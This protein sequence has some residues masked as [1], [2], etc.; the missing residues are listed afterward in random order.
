[1]S[2]WNQVSGIMAIDRGAIDE[3][4]ISMGLAFLL[5]QLLAWVYSCTHSGVSYSKSFVQSLV[6][7][8]VIVTL[9]MAIIGNNMVI[10]FGMLGALSM[11]RFRNV[12]KDTRDTAFVFFAIVNGIACGT[13]NYM[14]AVAGSVFFSV[15]L[16]YLHLIAFGS[17]RNSDAFIRFSAN[18]EL[19]KSNRIQRILQQHCFS[20]DMVTQRIGETGLMELAFQLILR[21]PKHG[22]ELVDELRHKTDLSSITF[23]HQADEDEV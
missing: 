19:W 16:F 21:D 6:M 15:L 1:M 13:F 17:R 5:G 20:A 18:I 14:L 2:Y 10:A 9:A 4:I 3:C 11:I 12:L 22:Y 7:L 23:L 8:T